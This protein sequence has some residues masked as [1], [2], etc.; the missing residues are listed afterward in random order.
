LINLVGNAIKY[1]TT[2]EVRV[3]VVALSKMADSIFR[4]LFIVHDTGEGIPEDQLESI[5]EPFV[6]G[7]SSYVRRYQGAGLGLSIVGRVVDLLGG[8]LTIESELEKGTSVYV[9]IPLKMPALRVTLPA[10]SYAGQSLQSGHGLRILF[11]E[12]DTVTRTSIKK[13][14]EKAGHHVTVAVDGFDALKKLEEGVFDLILMDIQMP[15]MDGLEATRII[16]FQ[17][18]FEAVRDIPIIALTAYAMSGDR[19]RF[20]GAGMNDY[21]SK[22]VDIEALKEVIVR[23]MSRRGTP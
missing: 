18:R 9:S 4:V 7:E 21:I 1:T 23:V 8:G 22:P 11:A 3:E 14:L 13:L 19:E 2:G 10:K 17:Y 20:I 16:R 15:Q 6:Q 12:D 5:F